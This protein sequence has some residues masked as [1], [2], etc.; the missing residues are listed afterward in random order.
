MQ[1]C[2]AEGNDHGVCVSH[3]GDKQ[4][5]VYPDRNACLYCGNTNKT[6]LFADEN[7]QAKKNYKITLIF[8]GYEVIEQ[9]VAQKS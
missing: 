7:D 3:G 5:I 9:K 2:C 4:G 6:K 1:I 8:D